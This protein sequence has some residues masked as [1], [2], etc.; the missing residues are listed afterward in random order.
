MADMTAL[1]EYNR[2][3]KSGEIQRTKP[4]SPEERAKANP[5]SRQLAIEAKCWDCCA[6]NKTEVSLCEITDCSLWHFR[7]WQPK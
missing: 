4:R 1:Q 7:P 5:Q 2:K 6:F 3:V